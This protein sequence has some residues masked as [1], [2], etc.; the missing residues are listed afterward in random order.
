MFLVTCWLL[1]MLP[2]AGQALILRQVVTLDRRA[3]WRSIA[4]TCTGVLIWSVAAAAGLSAVLL[5]NPTAY[6]LVRVAGGVVLGL[7]GVSSLRVM[8]RSRGRGEAEE[9][10]DV[11]G[12][13]LAGLATNL[14]NPKAGVFAISLIPQFIAP[15]AHVFASAVLLGLLWA[16]TTS[17]WYVVFVM[18]V[19]RARALVTRPVVRTWLHGVTGVVLL[20]LGLGVAFAV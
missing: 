4:G 18:G 14:G 7:L 9:V 6:A 20:L 5:A 19:D 17:T 11:R 12:A 13:F 10:V 1:A 8:R 16:L 3:A 2:G 15:G